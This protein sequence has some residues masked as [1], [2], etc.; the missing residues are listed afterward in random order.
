[1]GFGIVIHGKNGKTKARFTA[2]RWAHQAEYLVP[3]DGQIGLEGSNIWTHVFDFHGGHYFCSYRCFKI[4]LLKELCLSSALV[5]D[6]DADMT[7]CTN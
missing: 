7:L 6:L 5:A 3:I 4:G 1:M 2:S